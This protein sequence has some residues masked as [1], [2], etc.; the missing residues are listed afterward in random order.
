MNLQ[1]LDIKNEYR[2]LIDN[3]AKDFYIP[4]LKEAI[5][6]QR[7]VGFFSSSA[8][9]EISKGLIGFVRNGG[10]IQ[11]VASPCLTQEDIDAISKGY[12]LREKIVERALLRNLY[13]AETPYQ[14]SRLNLLSQLIADGV[15]DIKIAVLQ[16]QRDIGM[17]HEKMGIIHD[18]FGNKVAFAGSMNE[19]AT[20][21]MTNY[22]SID[23]F[24]SWTDDY[25]RVIAK[26]NAFIAIWNGCEPSIQTIDFP[27]LGQE[28]IKRYK[29][30]TTIDYNTENDE[31]EEMENNLVKEDNIIY[32]SSKPKKVGAAIPAS[33]SLHDYQL[34]AIDKWANHQYRG[35]FDMATGTGKTFTGLGALARLCEEVQSQLGVIIVCPFQHLVEQWVQDIKLFGMSPIIGYSR[36]P[37]KDWKKLLENAIRDQKFKVAGKHFFCFICTNATFSSNAVQT[38]LS[39]VK[40]ELL[41][42]V[43]EAH[44][45]G[46]T[47][48]S[49][50]LSERFTYRLALSATLERH[51]DEEG[52]EKLLLYFGKKCIEYT[53]ERAIEEKKLTPYKYYPVVISLTDDE[54]RRYEQLSFEMAHNLIKGKN[55]KIKL[56]K[57]GEILALKRARIVAGATE[58]INMLREKILPYKQE[59][60]SLVYCGATKILM[61][62]LDFTEIDDEDIRQIDLIT[63]L[64]GNELN[65]K[66]S[67]FTSKEDVEE[68]AILKQEF[69]KGENL[70]ALIAIKCLDEGVNIPKIKT[71]FIL[72]S[73]TNPKEYIQRRGR[74]LRLA[75]GKEYAE[76]YDFVTLP[77]P[78]SDV[79]SLTAEQA[80]RD[81]SLVRNEITRMEEFSRIAM[82]PMQAINIIGQIKETYHLYEGRT[83]FVFER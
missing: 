50:L 67:Q 47:N 57:Y 6:Y 45:F 49:K 12:E 27:N 26:E 64:L 34:S 37:Q 16:N 63:Q 13:E 18:E 41:L 55:G 20:G 78:L 65:M 2:S 19:T 76:I 60:F 10:R 68:R 48:L 44:N 74:V 59:S 81:L 62:D 36:S 35:I 23:V 61:D 43:D 15:L 82:N 80:K 40:G 42:M 79:T 1:Y 70:Q 17:Y 21:I 3:V 31:I 83:N 32:V 25:H 46:S 8:L 56:S 52:T 53:L 66:V 69:E 11:L 71:A 24:C 4:L 75:S 5:L 51:N 58:K 9:V 22:E 72:A 7:A 14:K 28:I 29:L 39:K 38:M 33:V 30:S 77:R 54:L 73:T